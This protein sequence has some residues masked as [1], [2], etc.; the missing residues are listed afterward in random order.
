MILKKASFFTICLLFLTQLTSFAQEKHYFQTDFSIADFQER[1]SQIFD[2]IGSNS[3]ALIQGAASVAGFKVFRQTN[4][5]YYLCGLEAEHSYLLLN[6]KSKTSTIY[7]P[8]RD[9][10]RERSQ[11]KILSAEDDDLVKKTQS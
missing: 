8:H 4:T 11:G 7:L 6:G 10:G 2:A 1:R 5:F 9:K 3:I